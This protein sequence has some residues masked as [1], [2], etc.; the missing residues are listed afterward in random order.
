M[1]R[2]C[3][4]CAFVKVP[5]CCVYERKVCQELHSQT[6]IIVCTHFSHVQTILHSQVA[7]LCVHVMCMLH[8]VSNFCEDPLQ[9]LGN[10]EVQN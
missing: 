1:E 8:Y 4:P 6:V 9:K 10:Q 2:R 3:D 5:L 7:L